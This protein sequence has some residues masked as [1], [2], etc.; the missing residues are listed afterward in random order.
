MTHQ[1]SICRVIHVI[2]NSEGA[3]IDGFCR[4]N[5]FDKLLR[6]HDEFNAEGRSLYRNDRGSQHYKYSVAA[7]KSNLKA[8]KLYGEHRIPLKLIKEQLLESGR[9]YE[10]IRT[11]MSSNEVVLITKEEQ[12]YLDRKSSFGGLGLRSKM[13][14]CGTD[15]L[16]FAGITIAEETLQNQL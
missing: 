15:R 11:I 8:S 4:G 13:P 14:K 7:F 1:E 6:S 16:T 5:P 10:K 3:I 9:S 2:L 12:Q